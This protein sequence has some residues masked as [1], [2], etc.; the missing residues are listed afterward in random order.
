MKTKIPIL[1]ATGLFITAIANAQF[2]SPFHDSRVVI[3]AHIGFPAPV[4]VAYNYD[5][6]QSPRAHYDVHRT[7]DYGYNIDHRDWRAEQYERYCRENRSYRMSREEFYRDRY[8]SRMSP[9]HTP[10]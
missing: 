9:Y 4:P 8:D 2:G 1:I 5:Y 10:R 3:Q 6:Y 7:V